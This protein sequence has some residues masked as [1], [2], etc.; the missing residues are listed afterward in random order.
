VPT[1]PAAA[2]RGPTHVVKTGKTP[3][4]DGGEWRR[5]IDAS[6]IG[7][8]LR[9]RTLI[10]TLTY[11]FARVTAARK[12]SGVEISARAAPD[13]NCACARKAAGITSCPAT[14]RW[15]RR[16][17]LTCRPLASPKIATAGYSAPPRDGNF[18]KPMREY[19]SERGPKKT[20][21]REA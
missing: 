5:L 20:D 7:R 19:R 13:E 10:T 11:S 15:P 12:M 3:V 18:R 8:E 2:V 16:C 14:T 21:A 17:R 6:D 4:L 9:D 1:N